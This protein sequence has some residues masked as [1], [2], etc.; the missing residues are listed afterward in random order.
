M[1]KRVIGVVL[2]MCLAHN[3]TAATCPVDFGQDQIEVLQFSYDMG[4]HEDLGWTLAA[5]AWKESSAG[6]EL[7]R[8]DGESYKMVSY[9]IYHSLLKYASKRAGC[10]SRACEGKVVQD[11]MTDPVKAAEEAIRVI[12]Y[13]QGYHGKDN[14]KAVWRGYNDG[15]QKSDAGYN[16]ADNIAQKVR[17]LKACLDLENGSKMSL[18]SPNLTIYGGV[19]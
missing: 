19:N 16:Y 2:G 10:K 8:I 18:G 15:F 12:Q 13:W 1:I 14:W 9:G 6:R 3:T 7:V 17:Y 11:L 4:K 5:I